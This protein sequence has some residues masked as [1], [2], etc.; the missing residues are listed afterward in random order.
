MVNST[1][2]SMIVD[3]G[4]GMFDDVTMSTIVLVL[5]KGA[6]GEDHKVE[7]RTSLNEPGS[8]SSQANY[9]T[10]GF[11]INTT[12]SGQDSVLLKHLDGTGQKLGHLCEELIF[13][14]VISGNKDDL[15]S[16]IPKRGWKAFLEGRDIERYRIR[17]T[18]KFLNYKP[19]E[20][21]RPRS[22][23]IFEA[24]EKLLIQ[25]I[26]GGARPLAVAYDNQQH[27]TK[28]SINNLLI[29]PTCR[30]DIKFILALLNS[31][32]LSWYYRLSFTNGSTLTVNLSK[33]YLSQL[34]VPDLDVATAQDRK[35][36]DQV[37]ALVDEMLGHAGV[38]SRRQE[39][40]DREI[41]ECVFKLFGLTRADAE[42]VGMPGKS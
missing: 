35:R 40:L 8:L 31:S 7:L 14:V 22:P 26:T 32:L 29:S 16:A 42:Y 5:R 34:P 36:H 19:G 11:V 9:R 6:P 4:A 12:A 2:L 30:F 23:R 13:G 28:E 27:Y 33:E 1:R 37:V 3:L 39:R 20:I 41:D 18:S 17:P 24:P 10:P 38:D 25:R 15:V 21:H